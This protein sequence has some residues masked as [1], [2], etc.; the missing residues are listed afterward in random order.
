[1]LYKP[2]PDGQNIPVLGL[3]TWRVGGDMSPDYSRDKQAIDTIQAA[4]QL[5]YTHI[6]TAEMYAAGH[7]EELVGEAIQACRR[8]DLFIATKVWHTHLRHQDV[9]NALS[10]SLERLQT[11]YI[12]LYLI[13]WPNRSIPLEETFRAL[14]ELVDHGQVRYL[15]VSN[16]ELDQLEHAQTLSDTPLLTN[17]VPYNISNRTY[18]RT[19]VLNYCQSNNILLTAYSPLDRGFLLRDI[20]IQRIAK[21]YAATPAQVALHWLVRQSNVIAIPM[22]ANKKHLLANLGALEVELLPEDLQKLDSI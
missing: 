8:Q 9:I 5:G 20:G 17:Q 10:G 19:G 6:D 18:A 21:K 12:D 4:I 11:D 16:F 3:G 7:T 22:S 13:H 2:L 1:M 15:G 14:N